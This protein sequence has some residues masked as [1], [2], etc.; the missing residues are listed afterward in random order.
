MARQRP[1]AVCDSAPLVG[2]VGRVARADRRQHDVAPVSFR[3]ELADRRPLTPAVAH[4]FMT[5]SN[6]CG[7]C[8]CDTPA[9]EAR[10]MTTGAGP[11]IDGRIRFPQRA[12]ADEPPG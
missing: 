5:Q 1:R 2:G 6:V 10:S 11:V 9:P 7:S 8:S 4:A 3:S 12:Q